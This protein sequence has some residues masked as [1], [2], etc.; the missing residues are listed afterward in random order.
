MVSGSGDFIS[1]MRLAS[2]EE[3]K[4]PENCVACHSCEKVCPQTIHIPDELRKFAV[5]VGRKS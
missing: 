3:G 1:G 4:G 5:K 2:L